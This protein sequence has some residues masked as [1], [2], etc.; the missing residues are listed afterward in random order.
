[1]EVLVPNRYLGVLAALGVGSGSLG[2]QSPTLASLTGHTGLTVK[3]YEID[4]PHSSIEFTVPFMGLSRVR[5]NFAD[6]G[7]TIMYDSTDVTRSSVSVVIEVASIDT[8]IKFRDEH[9][10]SPDFFDAKKY[11]LITFR[12]TRWERGSSGLLLCGT[13]TMHGVTRE[14]TLPVTQL[15]G[16]ERDAWGNRR[17]GFQAAT[18]LS[19][20]EFGILGTAFWNSEYDPGR[21]SVGDEVT[22]DLLIEGRVN[23]V[24]RWNNKV[25]DSLIAAGQHRSWGEVLDQFRE[26]FRDTASAAARG[27]SDALYN[28]AVK[29]VQRGDLNAAAQMV[30]AMVQLRPESGQAQALRGEVLLLQGR[31]EDAIAVFRQAHA[32]DSTNSAAAEYLRHLLP[33][34]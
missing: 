29:L 8:H 27:G 12:S 15:H 25:A 14:I 16:G 30:D 1:L 26:R 28:A 17:I 22:I 21:M 3:R 32:A 33:G 24:E 9:L 5:G 19:R 13:I 34:R 20:K 6:F 23:N 7:G 31:R 11:P 10:R 2:A 4:W 18:T